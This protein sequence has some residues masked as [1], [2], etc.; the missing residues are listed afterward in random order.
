V[1]GQDGRSAE[2]IQERIAEKS[3]SLAALRLIQQFQ[4]LDLTS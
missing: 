1:R 2:N 4:F 3:F